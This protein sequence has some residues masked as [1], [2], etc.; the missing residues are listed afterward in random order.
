MNKLELASGHADFPMLVADRI[1]KHYFN[2]GALTP[3][4]NIARLQ[5]RV[6]ERNLPFISESARW[7]IPAGYRDHDDWLDFQ[8]GWAMTQYF[9]IQ[10]QI[11][12]DRFKSAGMYPSI[13]AP[14]FNING[15]YQHGG[16]ISAGDT[17]TMTNPDGS[18][19]IYYTLDGTDVR[20]PGGGFSASKQTYTGPIPLNEATLVTARVLNGGQWSAANVATYSTGPIGEDTLVITELMYN[21][22]DP[23]HEFIEL[24]NISSDAIDLSGLTFS[25]GIA[26]TFP[27]NTVLQPS[28]FFIL[29]RNDDVL[30]F[31]AM[32]TG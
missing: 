7:G 22:T 11:L 20:A 21:S 10:T 14:V 19:T 32:Y 12:I 31:T 24:K 4:R 8:E 28:E 29:V 3:A 9:P 16:E 5:L 13:N 6:D 27:C 15:S 25:R 30:A 18:G 17:L 2:D 26:F 1:H 23:N